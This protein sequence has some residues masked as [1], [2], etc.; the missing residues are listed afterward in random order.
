MGK[1]NNS[2]RKEA[3]G[4]GVDPFRFDKGDVR[5]T[6]A[7]QKRERRA[8]VVFS[9]TLYRM[10]QNGSISQAAY[11]KGEEICMTI[12]AI[13]GSQIKSMLDT[14][15]I[16]SAAGKSANKIPVGVTD[17]AMGRAAKVRNWQAEAGEMWP[18]LV[19]VCAF[20]MSIKEAA[21]LVQ[22]RDGFVSASI[23]HV[24]EGLVW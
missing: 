15:V 11:E 13:E 1:K 3:I 17:T 12:E 21:K 18:A 23:K 8:E 22:R 9:T 2:I 10:R 20:G 16:A 14:D 7:P 5:V 6:A 24:L 4:L 19:A